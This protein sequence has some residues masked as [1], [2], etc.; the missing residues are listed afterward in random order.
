VKKFISSVGSLSKRYQK[1]RTQILIPI[2]LSSGK[3]LKLSAGKH[4][5]VEAGIIAEF[6]ARFAKGS[7]V[8]YLGDTA[9][10]DLYLDKKII[11][12][13][14]IP[15][16]EHSK[17]PDVLLYDRKKDWLFLIEAVTSHG[18]ISP[19]RLVE[20]EQLFKNCKSG[21]IYVTAFPDLGEMKK[22]ITNIA[23]ETEIWI[24]KFPDHMIHYNGD[25]FIGPR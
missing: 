8:I 7:A 13:L 9:N 10:K 6:A 12:E 19:K 5:E 3:K 25:K 23:W 17:L 4:N 20:L 2:T 14:E 15:I 18:P 24:Q 21:K 16:D 1:A 22:H 11:Q